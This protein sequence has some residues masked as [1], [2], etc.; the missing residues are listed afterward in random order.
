MECFDIGTGP[1][2]IN[3]MKKLICSKVAKFSG[4]MRFAL[5]MIF[6]YNF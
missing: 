6:L 3:D 2:L 4:M 1:V 5:E